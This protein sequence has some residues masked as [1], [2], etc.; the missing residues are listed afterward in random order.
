MYFNIDYLTTA[1]YY[2]TVY[3]VLLGASNWEERGT[4]GVIYFY[5]EREKGKHEGE[6][7]GKNT[8]TDPF[9]TRAP[10]LVNLK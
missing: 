10:P 9:T 4:A 1:N 2:I 6:G 7:R 5:W 3:R 8:A